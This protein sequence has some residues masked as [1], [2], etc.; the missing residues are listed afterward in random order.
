MRGWLWPPALLRPGRTPVVYCVA[1]GGCSTS[2]FDL[3]V[4]GRDDYSMA[5]YLSRRGAVVVAF[6]HPGLGDSSP[7]PD[8]YSV[9]PSVAAR[10]H[11][12]AVCY[13]RAGLRAGT[14]AHD[15]GPV[16]SQLMVGL[17]HSM[18]GMIAGVQQAQHRSYD[19][20]VSLGHSGSGLPEVLTDDELAL[21]G[22]APDVLAREN[23]IM[24]LA[25]IRFGPASGVPR[26]R[27]ARGV[28][29]ADDVPPEARDA[30]S[31]QAVPLLFTCGLASMIPDSAAAQL[32]AIEV[33]L[34]LGFGDQD[35]TDAYL[36]SAARYCSVTDLTLFVL[37][38][39]GHC[40]NLASGRARLWERIVKWL[41]VIR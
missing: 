7:L 34:Y 12:R 39:S 30:F 22:L 4:E 40:H 9:T 6:D 19:A 10:C 21:A 15:L 1:G 23:E 8:L 27:P 36:Q 26:R 31:R 16:E 13:V 25:R 2:Y 14:L 35:L 33:P 37:A 29:F 18:G 17:G 3:Q 11:D 28:F 24:R 32:A 38:G 41:D 20:L 5:G